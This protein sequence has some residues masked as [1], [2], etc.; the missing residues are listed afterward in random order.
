MSANGIADDV[1]MAI[2]G[3]RE[4]AACICDELARRMR[5]KTPDAASTIFAVESVAR[6]IRSGGHAPSR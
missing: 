4:R 6:M 3:E 2:L 1:R 5:A